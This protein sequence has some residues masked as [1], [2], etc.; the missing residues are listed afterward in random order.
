MLK[1]IYQYQEYKCALTG[2]PLDVSSK[3]W[4]PSLDRI[5]NNLGYFKGNIRIIAW[6]V[7]H[8]KLDLN[9]NEFIN[10]CNRVASYYTKY[11][12]TETCL[13]DLD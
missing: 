13:L 5:D 11:P 10:M 9:D 8:S 4:K 12:Y 3:W 7:N 1:D 2:V 6:I